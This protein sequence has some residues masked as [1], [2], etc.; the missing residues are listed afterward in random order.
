MEALA[1]LAF[2]D[3]DYL[4]AARYCRSLAEMA[5]DR[6]ENWFNLGV[7][8]HKLGNHEKAIQAYQQATTLQPDCAQ[9]H[10][11]LGVA[12]QEM[13]DLPAAR[14]CYEK[15]LEIDP[16]RPACCG[17]WRWCWS[18][19]ASATGPRSSTSAFPKKPPEWC[20]ATFRLG[21]L[22]L[23]RGDY[24]S[25]ADG[26]PDLHRAAARLAGSLPERRHRVCA[27]RRI[28]KRRAAISRRRS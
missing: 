24:Q 21:Y 13:S 9:A 22:R 3:G 1:T 5:P 26:V 8:Y 11:N 15:A 16:N 27:L 23:L 7:A 14:A 25:S 4:A 17:T 10:L 20:D 12:Q 6:F 19:R 28:R 18:S 2:A